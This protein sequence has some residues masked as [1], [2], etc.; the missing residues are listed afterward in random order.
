MEHTQ[1][2]INKI[3]EFVKE[4]YEEGW[5]HDIYELK[6]LYND[7]AEEFNLDVAFWIDWN[8]Y[9]GDDT[10]YAYVYINNIWSIVFDW[11]VNWYTDE[12]FYKD[13]VNYILELEEQAMKI[14]E[15]LLPITNQN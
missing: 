6:R 1:E 10:I 9:A 5:Y 11:D 15:K 12:N 8:E 4:K 14:R 3:N 13:T 7:I 2:F